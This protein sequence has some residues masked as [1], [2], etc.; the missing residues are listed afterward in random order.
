MCNVTKK[1]GKVVPYDFSEIKRAVEKSAAEVRGMKFEAGKIIPEVVYANGTHMTDKEWDGIESIIST[2]AKRTETVTTAMI[3]QWVIDALSIQSKDVAEAYRS[4]HVERKGWREG[5]IAAQAEA[6][7]MSITAT[8]RDNANV[9][10]G[11][12]SSLRVLSNAGHEKLLAMKQ[13]LD[14]QM[15][16]AHETGFLYVHD[17]A[18]LPF[19]LLNCSLPRFRYLVGHTVTINGT[20]YPKPQTLTECGRKLRILIFTIACN[21]F[22]GCTCCSVDQ[23]LAPYVKE[24]LRRKPNDVV[25]D[26]LLDLF[27]E[28]DI[29]FNTVGS[30]RGD[31]PFIT[32]TG[33]VP[34]KGEGLDEEAALVWAAAME[35]RKRG[36]G[37]PGKKRPFLFP[38]LVFLYDAELHGSGKP[39]HWLYEAGVECSSTCMYP[40]WLSLTGEGYV[41]SIYKRYG[42]IISPMGCRAF[43]SPWYR[44]GGIHPA[45]DMDVPEFLGRFNIGVVSLNLPMI[46]WECDKNVEAFWNF[47]EYHLLLIRKHFKRRVEKI[48]Q[49]PAGRNELL[50]CQGGV[51]DPRTGQG[52]FLS[53][54]EPVAPILSSATASFGITALNELQ[55]AY[56][57]K[58]LLEDGAFAMEVMRFINRK[59]QEYKEED[60]ILYAIYGTPAESLCGRQVQQF[61]ARYGIVKGVSDREYVSNS[62]HCHVTENITPIQKQ[63]AENRFWDYFNGG[64]IQYV[65]YPL[66]YN[67]KAIHTLL[68]RAMNMGFYEGINMDLNFCD[69]CGTR[70]GD[71]QTNLPG[72]C[73]VCGSTDRIVTINR[74][75]GYLGYSRTLKSGK[76][77]SRFNLAK[78]S[79]IRE[80]KSM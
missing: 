72:A 7:N 44:R 55:Q 32:I 37:E 76:G 18:A 26:L 23:I 13:F 49:M 6:E 17:L 36:H 27:T 43:L 46:Y 73:P 65:R 68:Q 70:F 51:L 52:S 30:S 58:S 15:I 19:Y 2:L 75:N 40:D 11:Q 74:M 38:K 54:D 48:G 78:M 9:D 56:N 50:F 79:E 45:D 10:A 39:L 20:D 8:N 35:V 22:G 77:S 25:W 42:E 41:P 12:S 1:S 80:R 4:Y 60:G 71:D 16:N 62:F 21:Q 24:E 64:K 14:P 3:H 29:L 31:Y 63:N 28:W 33:G 34:S 61:R 47:L 69:A 66:S 59:I 57:G 5:L 67:Q 53:P